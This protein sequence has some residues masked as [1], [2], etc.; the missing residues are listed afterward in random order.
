VIL[1]RQTLSNGAFALC[2]LRQWVGEINRCY[3]CLCSFFFREGFLN[4]STTI[5]VK[6]NF[7]FLFL[8]L[9]LPPNTTASFVYTFFVHMQSGFFTQNLDT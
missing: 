1:I 5:N 6:P 8:L 3:C 7:T 2:A 9:L 4:A